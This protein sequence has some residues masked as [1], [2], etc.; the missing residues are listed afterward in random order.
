MGNIVGNQFGLVASKNQE[1]AITDSKATGNEAKFYI[2]KNNS[3]NTGTTCNAAGNAEDG[4]ALTINGNVLRGMSKKQEET[5]NKY[6]DVNPATVY[7][8]KGTVATY[9]DLLKLTSVKAGDVYNVTDPTEADYPKETNFA[10]TKDGTGATKDIWDSLGGIGITITTADQLTLGTISNNDKITTFTLS[11]N[12]DYLNRN[13]AADCFKIG[14]E[15]PIKISSIVEGDIH[16]PVITMNLGSGLLVDGNNNL[17][18][19]DPS[20][21]SGEFL[22]AASN[23]QII[24]GTSVRFQSFPISVKK[25]ALQTYIKNTIKDTVQGDLSNGITVSTD[26]NGNRSIGIKLATNYNFINITHRFEDASD[27]LQLRDDINEEY[28][29][30]LYISSQAL[31]DLIVRISSSV[32][33][34]KIKMALDAK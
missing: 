23:E 2:T 10:A 1:T 28:G 24:E 4:I 17:S 13:K 31:H 3:D 33:A 9:D 20:L 16:I 30:G 7:K 27:I 22:E 5:V 26:S 6:I 15:K 34:E 12:S 25:S 8:F 14:V 29:K 19:G 18:V 21:V 11:A 32:A